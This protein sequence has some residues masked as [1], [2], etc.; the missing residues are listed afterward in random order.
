MY[1]NT[2]SPGDV[3][4]QLIV[5]LPTCPGDNFTFTCIVHGDMMGFIHWRVG[6]RNECVL[7]HSTHN[8][9][10]PCWKDSPFTVTYGPEF[11][12][13]ASS[14]T[15]VLSGTV[16]P[17]LNGMLVECFGPAMFRSAEN[18]VGSSTLQIIGKYVLFLSGLCVAM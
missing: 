1:G 13:R 12:T 14:F 11:G 9:P 16:T 17:T 7:L 4:G 18:M 15:S 8:D 6:G 5:T 2:F 3:A 10:H